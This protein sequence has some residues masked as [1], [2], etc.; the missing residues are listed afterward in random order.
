MTLPSKNKVPVSEIFSSYQGEGLHMGE[1]QVFVRFSGCNIKCNYCDTKHALKVC[2]QT[3]YMDVD[4]IIKKVSSVYKE[5]KE[6][7]IFGKPCV[8]LTG[9]E[10][11]IHFKILKDLIVKLKKANFKI[12]LETNGTLPKNLKEIIEYID[13]VSMDFKFES[14]CKKSFWKEHKEFLEIASNKVFVKCI[15]TSKTS[16]NE[17]KMSARIIRQIDSK[18]S[19]ILQPTT[20]FNIPKIIDIYKFHLIAKKIIPNVFL[21]FQMHKIFKIR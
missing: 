1:P 7:F 3:E 17:I 16:N 6:I 14:E 18:I 21:M 19:L 15:I 4:S 11:L 10:P 8:A 5:D 13:V 20:D 2:K 9:G 12:Y